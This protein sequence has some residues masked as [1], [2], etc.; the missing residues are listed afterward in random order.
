MLIIIQKH[1][2]LY[3]I[4]LATEE[5]RSL[6]Q[7]TVPGQQPQAQSHHSLRYLRHPT[8]SQYYNNGDIPVISITSVPQQWRHHT[9]RV[10][11]VISQLPQ[12]LPRK[13]GLN[14]SSLLSILVKSCKCYHL[15]RY[16]CSAIARKLEGATVHPYIQILLSNQYSIY[17]L[18][19]YSIFI[20]FIR[21]W[22]H[23]D[24]Q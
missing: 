9:L 18:W 13:E 21:Y 24:L 20:Q 6:Y 4:H 23:P 10:T 1:N 8:H 12:N 5:V 2:F 16:P 11:S 15:K 22:E 17:K 7:L 3:R 14:H 19:S